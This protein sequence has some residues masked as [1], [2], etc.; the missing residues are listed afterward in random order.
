[1]LQS[2]IRAGEFDRWVR[3]KRKVKSVGDA[4]S[5]YVDSWQVISLGD[6]KM[7]KKELPGQEVVV[8]DKLT[9]VQKTVFTGRYRSDL[10][11]ED[12]LICEGKAYQIISIT[13]TPGV[14]GVAMR[15]RYIDIVCNLLDTEE[16]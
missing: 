4:N 15:R 5:D 6:Q 8:A 3:F 13:E 12:R 14:N 9:F 7:R 2:G 11:T 16:T 1:M 10:T